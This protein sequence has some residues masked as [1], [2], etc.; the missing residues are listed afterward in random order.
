MCSVS[1]DKEEGLFLKTGWTG[2]AL[3]VLYRYTQICEPEAIYLIYIVL[4]FQ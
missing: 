2:I 1:C 4:S 3:H